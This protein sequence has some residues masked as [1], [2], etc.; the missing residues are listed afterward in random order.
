MAA[1]LK[2]GLISFGVLS[3][4][5]LCWLGVFS[6]RRWDE[7]G[8]AS[9]S[10][11]AV[12][13]GLSGIASGIVGLGRGLEVPQSGASVWYTVGTTGWVLAMAPWIVFALQYTGKQTEFRWR[14]V[15][16]LSGLI[17]VY[18][19]V[20]VAREVGIIGTGV[21]LQI[22]Q[23]PLFIYTIGVLSVGSYLLLRTTYNYGHLSLSL[24][25]SLTL[26]G[27]GP[28]LAL[29]SVGAL[30]ESASGPT[31]SAVYAL[32]SVT[33]AVGFALAVFR[34]DM[35]DSTPAAGA[36]GERAI[37]RETDDIVLVVDDAGRV[38]TLN[39]TAT[40]TL[41]VSSTDP[42]GES[43]ESLIGRTVTHFERRETV[44]LETT[45]GKRKFDPQATTFTDQH[46][47]SL[48]T[49]L[50][51]RDVTDRELRKQRLEVLN[52]VLRHNFRNEI[53]VIRANTRAIAAE[54]DV[55]YTQAVQATADRL[56][57]L[58]A[59]ARTTDEI[60]SQPKRTSRADLSDVVNELVGDETVALDLPASA[61]LDT[62]WDA[63][64]AVLNGAIENAV[65][66]AEESVT[67]R[68]KE[69]ADGYTIA[70]EDDGSG[71]P[72]SEL[73]ALNAETETQHQH[74]TGLG[75]WQIK[76]GVTKIGGDLSFDTTQGT[77]VWITVP[78]H[79]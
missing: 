43:I 13:L 52:R 15:T 1:L 47:R 36:L 32:A 21:I 9:F 49:L 69:S 6:H 23:T 46:G 4:L 53:D 3:G 38:I 19:V 20:T 7:P 55:K 59:K 14:D 48:G 8:V 51:L 76:W 78:D 17:G 29:Y 60:L 58:S 68:V 35:F 34:Y 2:S 54:T 74:G 24:G 44:D 75:L 16:A 42:L 73:A 33:P 66:Y 27:A 63:L 18:V 40:E 62:D 57:T 64:R 11:V 77:T 65:E 30:G 22:A 28:F 45:T 79:G 37:P 72:E 26:G 61:P 39:E 56:A 5:A 67:V 70:I 41:D 31:I 71:I 50:S 10:A 25:F 12:F